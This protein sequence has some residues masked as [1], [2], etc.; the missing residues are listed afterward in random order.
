MDDSD[1]DMIY[2]KL[3]QYEFEKLLERL[4]K[5]KLKLEKFMQELCYMA[6]KIDKIHNDCTITNVVAS[7]TGAVS[8]VLSILGITLAPV[9]AGGSLALFATGMG[10]GI[11]AGI[12][13]LSASIVDEVSASQGRK[14][15]NNVKKKSDDAMKGLAKEANRIIN[16]LSKFFPNDFP[17]SNKL[18]SNSGTW[19]LRKASFQSAK[20]FQRAV[21]S[22][23]TGARIMVSLE[24]GVFVLMH[25]ADIVK[26]SRHLL[27]GAKSTTAAELR[28]KAQNLREKLQELSEICK[29]LQETLN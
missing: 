27:N 13:R 28:E 24:V 5:M 20:D 26:D 3:Q 6:D 21:L 7:S 2:K 22:M 1:D 11:A 15:L 16:E 9:T 14:Y 18:A 4:L 12:T 19:R 8:G 23:S 25:V 10:L 17:F 29:A